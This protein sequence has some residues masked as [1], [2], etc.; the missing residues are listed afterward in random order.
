VRSNL[1]RR[2]TSRGTRSRSCEMRMTSC[3]E[4]ALSPTQGCRGAIPNRTS[5]NARPSGYINALGIH[6][7]AAVVTCQATDFVGGARQLC[8]VVWPPQLCCDARRTNSHARR[9]SAGNIPALS[10][11]GNRT[12]RYRRTT[13]IPTRYQRS[14]GRTREEPSKTERSVP[15]SARNIRLAGICRPANRWPFPLAGAI[16]RGLLAVSSLDFVAE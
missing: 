13:S 5:P 4:S 14:T 12:P 1:D 6:H 9:S 15:T 3:D 7:A 2:R 11:G 10:A 16:P 8:S